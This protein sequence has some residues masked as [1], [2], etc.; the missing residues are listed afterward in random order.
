MIGRTALLCAALLASAC[1]AEAGPVGPVVDAANILS[2][3]AEQSLDTR[4]GRYWDQK[5]TAIVVATVPSLKGETIDVTARRMFADWGIGSAPTNRGVLVLIAPNE[6]SARIEVGC[7]LETVLTNAAAKHILEGEMLP[8]FKDGEFEAGS[9]A[10]VEA[11]IKRI[12][13][14]NVAAGPVSP[15]C[16]EMMKDA[17]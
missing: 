15:F 1:A 13:T 2:P 9:T 16:V 12:D 5:E 14:A 3:Q 10:G 7:G 6:R 4:L 17:A 11:L 8:R